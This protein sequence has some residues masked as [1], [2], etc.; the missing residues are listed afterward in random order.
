MYYEISLPPGISAVGS[1]NLLNPLSGM[2]PCVSN[3]VVERYHSRGT[4]PRVKNGDPFQLRAEG[5]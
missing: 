1:G 3:D 2:A 5:V 4:R